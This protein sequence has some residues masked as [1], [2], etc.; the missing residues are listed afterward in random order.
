[1]INLYK[2]D[3]ETLYG[4][5]EFLLD[6]EEDLKDLPLDIK[7]GSSAMIIPTGKLFMLNY[8]KKWVLV[9]GSSSSENEINNEI[10]EQLLKHLEDNSNPHKIS[11]LSLGVNISAEALNNLPEDL[12][13]KI[14]ESALTPLKQD[15]SSIQKDVSIISDNI[16]VTANGLS[17]LSK[18]VANKAEKTSLN[19]YLLLSGGNVNGNLSIKG[20]SLDIYK[21]GN[22]QINF[23]YGSGNTTSSIEGGANNSVVLGGGTW[24]HLCV[25]GKDGCFYPLTNGNYSLGS[26]ASRFYKVWLLHSPEVSS[27]AELKTNIAPFN[28]CLKEIENTDIYS[29]KY[30]D[31]IEREGEDIDHIGLVIGEDYN[32][33]NKF[34]GKTKNGVDLYSSI[35]IAI[36]G[37]KELY[38]IVKELKEENAALKAI[39]F[40]EGE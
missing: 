17:D 20:N 25:N 29:Y 15:I 18:T 38:E 12:K 30:K 21:N 11:L 6:S 19:N 8:N 14:E 13:K 28:N 33:S 16:A 34:L 3:G 7:V 10:K 4:I 32:Y 39:L 36:G 37:I 31:V 40:K 5:K 1:M 2:Q 35:G 22:T 26:D 24:G 9:G 27:L 23:H